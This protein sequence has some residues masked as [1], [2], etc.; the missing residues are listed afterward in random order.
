MATWIAHMRIAEYFM[1][2][3]ASLNNTA[4]L[5]GN[6]G[7]DCGVPNN[8]WSQFTPDGNITHWKTG[9]KSTI[10]AEGFRRIYLQAKYEKY[11]F[12]MGY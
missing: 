10:D 8:D 6:I 12:F 5:V 9:D 1:D 4:F 7:P 3:Y 2:N 11:P